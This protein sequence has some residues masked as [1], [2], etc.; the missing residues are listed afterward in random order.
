MPGIGV[1]FSLLALLLGGL[2][3]FRHTSRATVGLLLPKY[4][5]TALALPAAIAGFIGAVLGWVYGSWVAT[6]AGL[7]GT[8]PATPARPILTS[9]AATWSKRWPWP[10]SP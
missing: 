8:R 2:P 9:T 4:L 1:T 10:I 7:V 6:V 3:L 5:G